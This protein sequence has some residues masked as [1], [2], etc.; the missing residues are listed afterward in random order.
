MNRKAGDVLFNLRPRGFGN[1]KD[2]HQL[3]AGN[4]G[5]LSKKLPFDLIAP[6]MTS[7]SPALACFL[8]AR[9]TFCRPPECRK[10]ASPAAL[11]HTFGVLTH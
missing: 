4:V 7:A 8:V 1:S 9:T 10:F 5:P 2:I 11:T 3:D 6:F